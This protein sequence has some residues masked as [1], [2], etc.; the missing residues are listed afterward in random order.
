MSLSPEHAAIRAITEAAQARLADIQTAREDFEPDDVV[1]GI[2]RR[3]PTPRRS[4]SWYFDAPSRASSLAALTDRSSNDVVTDVETLLDI[5]TRAGF[6]RP[7][8]V[9]LSPSSLP[10]AVVCAIVPGLETAMVGGAIG[11]TIA[12]ILDVTRDLPPHVRVC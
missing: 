11:P 5:F 8:I 12:A 4:G 1:A 7:E 6:D 2:A 10:I 9:D 3:R